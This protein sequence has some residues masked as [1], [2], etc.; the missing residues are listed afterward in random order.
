MAMLINFCAGQTDLPA[1]EYFHWF[2]IQEE[3][4]N[5]QLLHKAPILS[6]LPVQ[7]HPIQYFAN[8]DGTAPKDAIP[9]KANVSANNRTL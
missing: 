3:H 1:D 2:Q 4:N 5:M 7:A 8:A 6:M 9:A